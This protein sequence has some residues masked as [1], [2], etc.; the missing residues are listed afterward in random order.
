MPSA[1]MYRLC[2]ARRGRGSAFFVRAKVE[3]EVA[4]ERRQLPPAAVRI[5]VRGDLAFRD[6]RR[7]DVRDGVRRLERDRARDLR[8]EDVDAREEEG[9]LALGLAALA[10]ADHF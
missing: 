4:L 3:A 6:Q 10:E 5:D 1:T 8:L 7:I 2:S 9:V